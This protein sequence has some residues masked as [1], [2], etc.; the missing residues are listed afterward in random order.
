MFILVIW[1]QLAFG[2]REFSDPSCAT[3]AFVEL[4]NCVLL[5]YAV[6]DLG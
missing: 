1:L 4:N 3:F 5:D 6:G 2:L